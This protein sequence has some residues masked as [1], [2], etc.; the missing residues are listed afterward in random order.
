MIFIF[1]AYTCYG[2]VTAWLENNPV[3]VGDPVD[4]WS[5]IPG[6]LIPRMMADH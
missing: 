1:L 4:H 3:T 6:N 5:Q 2:E